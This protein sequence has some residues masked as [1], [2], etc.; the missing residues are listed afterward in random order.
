MM[1]DGVM[2][3]ES[4]HSQGMGGGLL[5]QSG[6]LTQAGGSIVCEGCRFC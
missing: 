4:S 1:L 5:L 3:A 2:T 6:V